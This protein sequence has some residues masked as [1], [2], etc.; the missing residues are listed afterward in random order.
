M[1]SKLALLL[2][3][4]LTVALVGTMVIGGGGAAVTVAAATGNLP[5]LSDGPRLVGEAASLPTATVSAPKTT[6]ADSVAP[7]PP[8]APTTTATPEA[9]TTHVAGLLVAFDP[10]SGTIS[11]QQ[12]DGSTVTLAVGP[13]T[14]VDGDQAHSLADLAN[15]LQARVEVE[16]TQQGDGSLLAQTIAVAGKVEPNETTVTGTVA[17]VDLS[18]GS[19]VL[20]ASDGS[21][22]T[23]MTSDTTEFG[24]GVRALSG[25][26]TGMVVNVQGTTQPDGTLAAYEVSMKQAEPNQPEHNASGRSEGSSSHA[27]ASTSG[28][29]D[30]GGDGGNGNGNGGSGGDAGSGAGGDGGD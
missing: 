21:S 7:A 24:G 25:L 29:G 9:V 13:T 28:S 3:S 18:S 14:H 23:V 16:A 4:K 30:H 22:M 2:Q 17:S 10:A 12:A 26:Q 19:F 11:V 6:P 15:V 27:S 5:V 1:W 8:V 20:T